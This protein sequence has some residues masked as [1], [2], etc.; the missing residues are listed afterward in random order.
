MT[1]RYFYCL[2]LLIASSCGDNK[3]REAVEK[4]FDHFNHHNWKKMAALYTEKAAFLDPSLGKTK[5]ILTREEIITK[6]TSL[7]KAFPDVHDSILTISCIG[8]N[9]VLVEFISSA[10]TAN[11]V[12]W[13]LPICSVF[14]LNNGLI[15]EDYTYYDN[16]N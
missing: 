14:S 16:C 13:Q 9:Q 8:K 4:L 6:Y 7:S 1:T 10:T 5:V 12:K 15:A 3:N 11:G 2:L